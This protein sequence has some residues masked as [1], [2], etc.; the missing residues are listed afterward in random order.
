MNS[1]GL[2]LFATLVGFAGFVGTGLSI[3]NMA[4]GDQSVSYSAPSKAEV[5]NA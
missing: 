3:L 5:C 1:P 4:H 2:P